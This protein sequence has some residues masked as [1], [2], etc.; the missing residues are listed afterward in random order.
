[1]SVP[2]SVAQLAAGPTHEPPPIGPHIW[3]A[4]RLARRQFD[5]CRGLVPLDELEGEAVCA[6]VYA[7]RRF[8][9]ARQVPFGAYLTMVIRHRLIH[10]VT[11]WCRGGRLVHTRF[12]DLEDAPQSKPGG[13]FDTP[14]PRTRD[15]DDEAAV[16]EML[17]KVRRLVPPRSFQ[18]LQLYYAHGHTLEEVGDIL[19]VSRERVR[20]MIQMAIDQVRRRHPNLVDEPPG[21]KS[22]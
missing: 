9:P 13:R 22:A 5:R 2:E 4:Y 19:G 12:T 18:A 8:D 16:R 20:Q 15:V 6:L 1:M 14:C 11:T 17:E 3:L 7:S 21:N 10:V